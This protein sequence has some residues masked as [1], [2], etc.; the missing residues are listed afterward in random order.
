MSGK[1]LLVDCVGK[2]NNSIYHVMEQSFP[3]IPYKKRKIKN[4]SIF[5]FAS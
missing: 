5:I 2:F 3:F 1:N 4:R